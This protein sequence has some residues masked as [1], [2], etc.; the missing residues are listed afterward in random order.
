M[1]DVLI[2]L[3]VFRPVLSLPRFSPSFFSN[4]V[5]STWKEIPTSKLVYILGKFNEKC[6]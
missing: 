6:M 4:D 3:G 5:I 1:I 2:T